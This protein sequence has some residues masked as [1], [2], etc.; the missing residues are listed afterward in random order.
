M[1]FLQETGRR[2]G[3]LFVSY[4]LISLFL[5]FTAAPSIWLSLKSA[6]SGNSILEILLG[7]HF[8]AGALLGCLVFVIVRISFLFSSPA[9]SKVM[10][11]EIGM[12]ILFMI[13]TGVIL[14]V[15]YL[16]ADPARI[17]LWSDRL[18]MADKFIFRGF[19][20][21]LMYDH[22]NSVLERIIV[23][24][25]LAIPFVMSIWTTALI[26]KGK[27]EYFAVWA[28]RLFISFALC[29]ALWIAIPAISPLSMYVVNLFNAP[30]S[31]E[32]STAIKQGPPSV[33]ID[34]QSLSIGASWVDRSGQRKAVSTFPSMHVI[35]GFLFLLSVTEVLKYRVISILAALFACAN[36]LGAIY[37]LQHYGVDA[38]AAIII[39]IIAILIVRKIPVENRA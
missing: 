14:D 17:I 1:H 24:S 10:L 3:F 30:I 15:I 20:A 12:F 8:I 16:A 26:I 38:L 22:Y 31:P 18:M 4:S 21:F 29:L 7:Q 27:V 6:L 39:C 25:Y 28:K 2:Y 36:A 37:V 11:I 9:A 19:P 5:V 32:V 34:E 23:W 13:W 33:F 35:W